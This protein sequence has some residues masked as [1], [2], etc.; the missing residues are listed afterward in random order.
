MN[1]AGV[2]R[3][4]LVIKYSIRSGQRK[5]YQKFNFASQ[6]LVLKL[7]IVLIN[8]AVICHHAAQGPPCIYIYLAVGAG[9][10]L[11]HVVR[12]W[13]SSFLTTEDHVRIVDGL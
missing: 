3:S 1:S 9:L 5:E 8:C 13:F 11:C 6:M 7:G 12:P 2:L 4:L 10:A